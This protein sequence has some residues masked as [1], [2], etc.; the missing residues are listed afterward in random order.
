MSCER[1][2]DELFKS[3]WCVEVAARE[4]PRAHAAAHSELLVCLPT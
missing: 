1:T 2:C 4:L 3:Q